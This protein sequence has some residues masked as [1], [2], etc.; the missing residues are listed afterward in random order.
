MKQMESFRKCLTR[1]YCLGELCAV[2]PISLGGGHQ[3]TET[4]LSP[5]GVLGNKKALITMRD[6]RGDGFL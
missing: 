6:I 5:K 2:N 3:K 1:K 4:D